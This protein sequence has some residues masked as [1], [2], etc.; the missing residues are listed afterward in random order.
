MPTEYTKPKHEHMDAL[1]NLY[2]KLSPGGFVIIDDYN[3]VQA[4][5][6]A[7]DEFRKRNGIDAELFLIPGAGAFWGK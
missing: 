3:T 2:P 6:D 1:V 5:N 4:C 7:V